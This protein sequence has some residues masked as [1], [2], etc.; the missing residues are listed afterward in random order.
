MTTP[1]RNRPG[2][3]IDLAD[4]RAALDGAMIET[5]YQPIIRM[6]DREPVGLEALARL[7]HPTLGTLL[8]DQF[9]PQMED[10]GLAARLTE[11]VSAQV[12][13][14]LASPLLATS[15]ITISLNFPLD[16]LLHDA[17]L[18]LL[19]Q[20]RVGSGIPAQRL[21]IEL[22]ESQPVQDMATLRHA[23]DHLRGL[24]YGVAIDDV[25]PAV[26]R[27]RP[28]LDLPFTSLK[29]DKELV[30]QV[31]VS[32]QIRDFLAATVVEA[33]QHGLSVVAEGVETQVIWDT[34]LGMGADYAQGFLAARPLP[35][36]AVPIWLQA[37]REG[38][39]QLPAGVPVALPPDPEP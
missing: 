32:P 2:A 37:W 17:S 23:L 11:L 39:G 13:A 29:L 33:K 26:P 35:L 10:A 30:K 12:F 28:M 16:V 1:S 9:V 5:R 14:D 20:Q 7:A 19:E 8:P 24:G 15:N 21:I 38:P 22:T 6:A 4:L 34:M 36:V 25:G 31:D 27:F 3:A 18:R